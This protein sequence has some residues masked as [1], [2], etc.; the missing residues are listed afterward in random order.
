MTIILPGS[1]DTI[2]TVPVPDTAAEPVSGRV[3]VRDFGESLVRPIGPVQQAA[4]LCLVD[5]SLH[6]ATRAFDDFAMELTATDGDIEAWPDRFTA[7]AKRIHDEFA[8]RIPDGPSR[9][10]FD[11]GFD[12]FAKAKAV[13]TRGLAT[14]KRIA[15][16][17]AELDRALAGYSESISRAMNPVSAGFALSQGET[18]IRNQVAA[19]VLSAEEG[20]ALSRRYREDIALRRARQFTDDDP[21]AA[22]SE[23]KKDKGGLFADLDPAQRHALAGHAESTVA[24]RK[25]D[26][27]RA[28]IV[29]ARRAESARS[30]RRDAFLR[31]L[32]DRTENGDAA[33]SDIANAARDGV[34]EP[35]EVDARIRTLQIDLD[36]RGQTAARVAGLV[37]QGEEFL[38]PDDADDRRA[39][40]IHWNDVV[41]PL[42]ADMPPDRRAEIEDSVVTGTGIVPKPLA[43]ELRAG[44]LSGDPASQVQSARRIHRWILSQPPI[45]VDKNGLRIPEFEAI[46]PYLDLPLSESRIVALAGRDAEMRHRDIDPGFTIEFN[47]PDPDPAFSRNPF[48]P[49]DDG[50]ATQF[51]KVLDDLFSVGYGRET[52]LGRQSTEL[53]NAL[54]SGDPDPAQFSEL[55]SLA[56]TEI[57]QLLGRRETSADKTGVPGNVDAN[58]IAVLGQILRWLGGQAGR[59]LKRG[60][61]RDP[62][63]KPRVARSEDR[64]PTPSLP[65]PDTRPDGERSPDSAP[66]GRG[67]NNPPGA[68]DDREDIGS[69]L[70]VQG[71]RNSRFWS[72]FVDAVKRIPGDKSRKAAEKLV[73]GGKLDTTPGTRGNISS[74]TRRGTL[75]DALD[76]FNRAVE[77]A[78]GTKNDIEFKI[79]RGSERFLQYTAPDKTEFIHRE[80]SG[81]NLPTVELQVRYEQQGKVNEF[82]KVRFDDVGLATSSP[83]SGTEDAG[84]RG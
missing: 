55:M 31:D 23:L 29:E 67:H 62:R 41:T 70:N 57:G 66:P 32:R 12:L 77:A 71:D 25:M 17:R 40:E 33:L 49:V 18:A 30:L 6:D 13:E 52:P 27:E 82:I 79:G 72:R 34:L 28:G 7:E 56:G 16:N 48:T 58:Q 84:S 83:D 63:E 9:D 78:G 26:A 8:N 11:A 22:A 61:K 68:P 74:I 4:E 51:A 64:T 60:P 3:A 10:R 43:D 36:A 59:F 14:H 65:R 20:E 69:R 46:R 2:S 21:E 76:S 53:L 50:D 73:D 75:Q 44:L 37:T 5:C 1:D 19:K 24:A 54:H 81:K 35:D 39:A 47:D 80:S 15:T 38:N 42:T 45:P